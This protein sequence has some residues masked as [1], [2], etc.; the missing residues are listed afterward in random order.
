MKLKPV[1]QERNRKK[2]KRQKKLI[3]S[4]LKFQLYNVLMQ[5]SGATGGECVKQGPERKTA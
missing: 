5:A 4:V 1:V 3:F 2:E